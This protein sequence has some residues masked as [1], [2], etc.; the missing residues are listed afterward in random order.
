ML[1]PDEESSASKPETINPWELTLGM[2][3][4]SRI[5]II[6]LLIGF[7]MAIKYSFEVLHL[8]PQVIAFLKILVGFTSAGGLLITG[9]YLFKKY[10]ILGRVLQSGGLVL[11]YLSL[12]G[13]FFIPE[14]QLVHTHVLTIG[15]PLLIAYVAL[16]ITLA[17][18]F[19]SKTLALLS[20]A[21]GYYTASFSGSQIQAFATAGILAVASVML[22]R[23]QAGW[24]LVSIASMAG[25]LMTFCYWNML[26]PASNSSIFGVYEEQKL[27]LWFHFIVFH[28]GNLFPAQQTNQ[29]STALNILNTFVFYTLYQ[30]LTQH[31]WPAGLFEASLALCHLLSYGYLLLQK[32]EVVKSAL[33]TGT[34]AQSNLALGLWFVA[35]AS[36]NHFGALMQPV[37]LGVEAL[38]L[39]FLALRISS[40]GLHR[41]VYQYASYGFWVASF[42]SLFL[43][44]WSAMAAWPLI[45]TV[46][47]VCTI[48]LLLEH[49][50]VSRHIDPQDAF[51]ARTPIMG[52]CFL[53]FFAS[54]VMALETHFLTLG[55][56]ATCLLF[57]IAGFMTGAKK[58]RWTGLLWLM[59][60]LIHLIFVDIPTLDTLYKIYAFLGLGVVMLGGSFAYHALNQRLIVKDNSTEKTKEN[61]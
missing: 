51:I 39:A 12:Y 56:L 37:V 2:K 15:W 42:V 47:G 1:K 29:A 14:V 57:M 31:D 22:S 38:A 53:T 50:L 28:L 58:Y 61:E 18:R 25:T 19:N 60:S 36:L 7:V 20:L 40:Q 44:H 59:V 13:M 46:G 32:D 26:A 23:Y 30:F 54:L 4:F 41:R 17:R 16:M 49:A 8:D 9:H 55:F 45:L 35:L 24:R 43:M 52:V 48:G 5:G 10:A 3:W 6:A 33:K 34:F 21:F 27:F 11:G